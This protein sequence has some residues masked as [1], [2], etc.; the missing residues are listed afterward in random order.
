M[1]FREEF[2][3]SIPFNW[4]QPVAALAL[5]FFGHLFFIPE[6]TAFV[7]SLGF[8]THRDVFLFN[9][10]LIGILLGLIVLIMSSLAKEDI[11][12]WTWSKRLT[13]II[14]HVFFVYI[15]LI[16]TNAIISQFSSQLTSEN[17][18][19]I[20]EVF[21]EAPLYIVFVAIVFAPIVEEVLFR[22]IIYRSLRY[23]KFKYIAIII[24]SFLFGTLHVYESILIARF[25]DLWFIPVYMAIGWFM[26]VIYEKSGDI[27]TP[28]AFHM[29]YNAIAVLTLLFI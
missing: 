29:I 23:F 14:K 15:A 8:L 25:E 13:E 3:N 24:S 17:Q 28:I 1:K 12:K 6:I 7:F 16:A 27:L 22:G 10:I 26:S 20:M 4:K 5:Y 18:L 9:A 19:L 21:K 11:E 2:E